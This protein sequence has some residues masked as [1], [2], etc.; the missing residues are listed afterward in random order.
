MEISSTILALNYQENFAE[1]K[2]AKNYLIFVIEEEINT[3]EVDKIKQ[4]F[5]ENNLGKVLPIF[6]QNDGSAF[7]LIFED[8]EKLENLLKKLKRLLWEAGVLLSSKIVL[9]NPEIRILKDYGIGE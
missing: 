1:I 8:I 9:V 6:I 4:F 2:K 3:S 5:S 7:S